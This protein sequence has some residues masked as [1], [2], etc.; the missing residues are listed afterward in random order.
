VGG[1]VKKPVTEA[2]A[3]FI[4]DRHIE[5]STMRK[6]KRIM[7]RLEEFAKREQIPTIDQFRLEDLDGYRASRELCA[8]S[9]AK[10]LQLRRTFFWVL[11]YLTFRGG[12]AIIDS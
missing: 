3:A 1:R 8:L 2:S 10:E 4:A 6:Y 5:G 11:I 9:W 12:G 7:T